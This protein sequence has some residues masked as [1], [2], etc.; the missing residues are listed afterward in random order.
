[1]GNPKGVAMTTAPVHQALNPYA[2]PSA[3][4]DDP[5]VQTE[6]EAGF[7]SVSLG[8]L[9]IMYFA[10]FGLYELYWFYRNWKS[11]Q[12]LTGRKLSALIRTFFF[13]LTSFGLFDHIRVQGAKAGVRVSFQPALMALAVFALNLMSH[14]PDPY[15]LLSALGV[16]PL[17]RA[18][19]A[20]NAIN[21]AIAP[22]AGLNDRLSRWN[23]VGLAVG[24]PAFALGVIGAFVR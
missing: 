1:V 5:Q 20:V 2:P 18:Q 23:I 13:P 11:V 24:G 8:K 9:A 6:V 16:V 14:L 4:V 17:L 22:G 19:T 15:W 21:R 10:T 7:F 3:P 12:R